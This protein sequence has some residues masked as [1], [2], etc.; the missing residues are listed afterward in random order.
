MSEDLKAPFVATL[1]AGQGFDSPWLVVSANT[2]SELADRLIEVNQFNLEGIIAASAAQLQAAYAAAKGAGATPVAQA[3]RP[4]EVI[5]GQIVGNAP[6]YAPPAAVP[7]GNAPSC[8]HG[9]REWK[10]FTSKA[11]NHVK[12]WFCA[13]SFRTDCKPQYAK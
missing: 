4:P 6:T 1:K 5:A 10:D 7:A 9:P 12:G 13:A 8:P 11:G 2:T 3:P